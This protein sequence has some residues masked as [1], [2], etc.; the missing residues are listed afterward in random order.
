MMNLVPKPFLR[1]S[2]RE[3]KAK[4]QMLK[5]YRISPSPGAGGY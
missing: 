4:A 2:R 5:P 3:D 1:R